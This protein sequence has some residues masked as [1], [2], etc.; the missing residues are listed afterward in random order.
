MRLINSD[1]LLGALDATFEGCDYTIVANIVK[2]TP[3]VMQWVSVDTDLPEYESKVLV[4]TERNTMPYSYGFAE[5][6]G[7]GRWN[8]LCGEYGKVTHWTPL[9][10]PPSK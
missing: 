10:P 9:P 5:H 7:N 6:K 3:T 8:L 1:R 4:L 2:N